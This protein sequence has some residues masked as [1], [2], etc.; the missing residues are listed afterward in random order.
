MKVQISQ[1]LCFSVIGHKQN[2]EDTL[3]PLAG[4]ASD[5]SKLL[6]VCD[7]MGGHE[8]GEVASACVAKVIGEYV[9]S[10]PMCKIAEMKTIFE[11]GLELAYAELDRLDTGDSVK[12]M[13]TTLTFLCLCEDGYLAAHIGDSRIYQFRPGIGV[14][15]QT[16]DH[17]LVNDLVAAGEITPEEARNHPQKNVITRAIQPH[18]EYPCKATFKAITDVQKGDLFFLCCDGVVEQLDNDDLCRMLL[19]DKSLQ[20]R[21]DDVQAECAARNTRDNH[22]CYLFEIKESDVLPVVVS[23]VSEATAAPRQAAP[24]VGPAPRRQPQP[25]KSEP[26]SSMLKPMLITAAGVIV[27]AAIGIA[28]F[29]ILNKQEDPKMEL[30]GDKPTKVE[31]V[32]VTDEEEEFVP[33]R[34]TGGSEPIRR[35]NISRPVHDHDYPAGGE[36]PVVKPRPARDNAT[37][38]SGTSTSSGG[39]ETSVEKPNGGKMNAN[40]VNKIRQQ[41]GGGESSGESH[42]GGIDSEGKNKRNNDGEDPSG[43]G[44]DNSNPNWEGV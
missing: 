1:P 30:N 2:Q 24:A 31:K 6:M 12:K 39:N 21:L 32:K 11:E 38:P 25:A 29:L 33:E 19:S 7:G 16:R 43:Q 26:S 23:A 13:G 44:K 9:D 41:I 3:Y 37:L 27:V 14:I 42:G 18:M 15:F 40:D 36:A 22:T 10:K 5:Q 34:N 17:S 8:H 35:E 4:M 28:A 20:E